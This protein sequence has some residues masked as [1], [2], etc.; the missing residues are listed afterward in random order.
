MINFTFT[1]TLNLL[2]SDK[3]LVLDHLGHLNAGTA[4]GR[5]PLVDHPDHYNQGAIEC[6]DALEAAS[7]PEEFAGW[8]RLTIMKYLWRMRAKDGRRDL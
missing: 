2:D 3:P 1:E 6:I 4:A 8:L 5:D 7:S